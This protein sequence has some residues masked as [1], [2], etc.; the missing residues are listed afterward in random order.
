MT[1]LLLTAFEAFHD[2]KI[3]SSLEVVKHLSSTVML[4]NVDT[5]ILP[6]N[7]SQAPS[8]IT[9]LLTSRKPEFCLMLGQMKEYTFN[10]ALLVE[11]LAIN[12]CDFSIPDNAGMRLVD[13]P[14]IQDGPLMYYSTAPVRR[15]AE[16]INAAGTPAYLS[17]SAGSFL[18]NMV[19]YVALHVC[20]T[21]QLSTRCLFIHLPILPSQ[22]KKY[23][24]PSLA[25]DFD[26]M[27]K[28]VLTAIHACESA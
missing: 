5:A 11:R 28:G 9:D 25:M 6:V 24:D 20:A 4:E 14:I 15:V 10:P 22:L 12:L 26:S 18:C 7:A 8:M 27:C 1:S 17:L 2:F 16:A 19:Y 3:N 13:E 23:Q 21:R